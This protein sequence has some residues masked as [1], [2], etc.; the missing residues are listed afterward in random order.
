ME[1]FIQPVIDWLSQHA[2]IGVLI[3]IFLLVHTALKGFQDGLEKLRLEYDKT[4]ET[5]DNAFEKFVTRFGKFM[6]L[7]GLVA[8]YAAGIRV[9]K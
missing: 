5:D 6:R 9:K 8:K 4:P 1:Q 3:S 2:W 7:L